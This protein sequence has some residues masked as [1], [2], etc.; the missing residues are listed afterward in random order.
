MQT[1]GQLKTKIKTRLWPSGEAKSLVVPHDAAFQ[2]A[3]LDLQKW[4]PCLKQ[5][6]VSTWESATR[7]W[8]NGKTV[9]TAPFGQIRRVYTVAGGTDRWRD[10]V[11]YRSSTFEEIECWARLLYDAVTPVNA[12]KAPL[13]FGFKWEEEASDS[14]VGRARVGIWAVHRKRLYIA[15]WLQSN[16]LLVVEWDGEKIEWLDSDGVDPTYWRPD[17]EYAIECFVGYRHELRYGDRSLAGDLWEQ[18]KSTRAD[19]MHWCRENTRMIG[20]H[21]CNADGG[22]DNLA[23]VGPPDGSDNTEDDDDPT[24]DTTEEDNV[25]FDFV[26]DVED[27][28]EGEPLAAAIQSDNPELLILGGDIGYAA[29]NG[30]YAAALAPFGW[31]K[32]AGIILPAIGNHEYDD[33]ADLSNYFDFF[34]NEL[35]GRN[36]Q[37]YYEFSHGPLHGFVE[38]RNAQE[39]D[40]KD[41][42]SIQAEWL[43]AKATL[44]PARWKFAFGHQPPFSSGTVHGSDPDL[45]RPYAAA[46][47]QVVFSAHEHHFEHLLIGGVHYINCGLGGRSLYPFGTPIAGSLFRYN[48]T[49]ARVRVRL[50]CDQCVIELVTTVGDIVYSYTIEHE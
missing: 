34:A 18:Y 1:F 21:L 26:G 41:N 24:E 11:F 4:V 19:I 38:N 46:G 42:D 27:T 17:T 5:F 28:E 33:D 29:D 6:N 25:L 36:N 47:I 20:S 50:D 10:K 49:E 13:E 30:G 12:G 9:V 22:G 7:N 31:A 8:E 40:G 23:L 48:T 14:T 44:S 15:P 37:R 3:M 32:T 39:P 2:Q 16:E 45:Q 43:L 35:A